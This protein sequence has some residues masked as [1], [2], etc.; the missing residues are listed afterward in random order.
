MPETPK[1]TYNPGVFDFASPADAMK[2]ILTPEG[3]LTTEQRWARETPYLATLMADAVAIDSN[4][5]I[6]DYG[7][8][9]GRM[10]R[11]LI[12]RHGCRII[13]A[14]ISASM[15]ALAAAYVGSE[16]FLA[17]SP[18]MLDDLVWRGIVFDAALSVWVL[19][20]CIEPE[21]DVARIKR[22]LKPGGQLFVVNNI[23]RAVPT[24]ERPWVND[25]I[26]MRALLGREFQAGPVRALDAAQVDA[27]V[28][29]HSFCASFSR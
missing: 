11:A 7:C 18:D 5:L 17:C 8:G 6:L 22:A 16:R 23:T 10:A 4:S 1:L 3:A 12:E 9:V 27:F 24:V 15:R 14:D 20:H 26:D 21:T 25:G 19:Q 28:A 2:I 29:E 13:G